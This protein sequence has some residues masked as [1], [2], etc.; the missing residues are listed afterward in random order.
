RWKLLHFT[1]YAAALLLFVH[2]LLTDPKLKDAPL[3]PLDAEKVYVEFCMCAV[4]VGIGL[5]L[6][7]QRRQGPPRVHRPKAP[8]P[9]A[10]R[11]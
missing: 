7:W 5:R 8:R 1:A 4:A 6:R 10:A 9:A 2:A 11:R 3:D